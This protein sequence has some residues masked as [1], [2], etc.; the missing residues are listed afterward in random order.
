MPSEPAMPIRA[1]LL[2]AALAVLLSVLGV[3]AAAHAQEPPTGFRPFAPDSIWNL[4]LR[5]DAPLLPGGDAQVSWLKQQVVSSGAWINTT[6]CGMPLHW[7][8]PDTPRVKVALA[9]TSY[10]E[11]AL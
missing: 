1:R 3:P 9:S 6:S 10:Q 8:A 7:A 5:A 4:L 2:T 11:K